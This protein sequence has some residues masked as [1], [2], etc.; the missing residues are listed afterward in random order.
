MALYEK[1][2]IKYID[3]MYKGVDKA[4]DDIIHVTCSGYISPSPVERFASRKEWLQ[5]LHIVITWG[6]MARCLP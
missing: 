4:P 3:E 2:A 5:P 6:A 1:T